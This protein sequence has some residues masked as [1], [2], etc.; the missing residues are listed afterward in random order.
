[1]FSQA[2]FPQAI[3]K[4]SYTVLISP[5]PFLLIGHYILLNQGKVKSALELKKENQVKDI[6]LLIFPKAVCGPNPVDQHVGAAG[7]K[8]ERK[9]PPLF[10]Y[11]K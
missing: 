8:G 2:L 3:V 7:S 9:C 4:T 6:G 5:S 11:L 10:S 1:M